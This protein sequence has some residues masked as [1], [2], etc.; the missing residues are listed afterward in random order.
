VIVVADGDFYKKS[1]IKQ[2]VN[3]L[4]ENFGIKIVLKT[5]ELFLSWPPDFELIHEHVGCAAKESQEI[6][7]V[8]AETGCNVRDWLRMRDQRNRSAIWS[9]KG[10]T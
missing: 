1:L 9:M 4:F 5:R 2:A 7:P 10:S 8:C 6:V 3:Q